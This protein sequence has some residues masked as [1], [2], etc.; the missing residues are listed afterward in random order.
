MAAIK[1]TLALF[2]SATLLA[3]VSSVPA[4]ADTTGSGDPA[5]VEQKFHKAIQ[6]AEAEDWHNAASLLQ[7]LHRQWPANRAIANNLAVVFFNQGRIDKAQELLA[8]I[9]ESNSETRISFQNLQMLYGYVTA[10]A[11]RQG[12]GSSRK[13]KLPPLILKRSL[14]PPAPPEE[15]GPPPT[16]PAEIATT[17]APA[18][19]QTAAEPVAEGRDLAL[20]EA[21]RRLLDWAA[22]WSAGDADSYI[23]FYVPD[24]SPPGSSRKSWLR[25][26]RRKI[27]PARD[28]RVT[29]SIQDVL[30]ND[31]SQAITAIFAQ[32]Y[33]SRNYH[34]K[35]RKQ[36]IWVHKNGQWCIQ[37]ER[38]IP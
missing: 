15:T 5:D 36:M 10:E 23:S 24:Y 3:I 28:I 16:G 34:D 2:L 7:E 35:V 37:E 29:L 19:L 31:A 26:R 30:I 21:R 33:I 8:E 18:A 32:D 12:L 14:A 20:Q 4:Y 6:L 22:A 1:K 13:T 25:D 9:L 17:P 27:T 11:Y 38:T